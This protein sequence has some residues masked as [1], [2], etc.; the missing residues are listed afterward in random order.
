MYRQ[1]NQMLTPQQ[2]R[3]PYDVSLQEVMITLD[4]RVR[5]IYSMRCCNAIACFRVTA[6]HNI[7][8]L[9]TGPSL[10][11][12]VTLTG[13]QYIWLICY[14]IHT[15]Q[16]EIHAWLDAHGDQLDRAAYKM[17]CELQVNPRLLTEVIKTLKGATDS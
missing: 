10:P 2:F 3:Y 15:K 13:Q 6:L 5:Q 16:T 8:R 1:L 4:D 9:Y 14:L 12:L 17:V 11:Q 7:I